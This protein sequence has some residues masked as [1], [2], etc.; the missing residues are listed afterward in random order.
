[1]AMWKTLFGRC[2]SEARWSTSGGTVWGSYEPDLRGT[3]AGSWADA[4][5]IK[6]VV[7]D[8]AA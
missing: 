3:P 1:M 6:L 7:V 8:T 4:L 5:L 2:D